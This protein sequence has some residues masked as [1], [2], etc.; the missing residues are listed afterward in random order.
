MATK[1]GV[2]RSEESRAKRKRVKA[3]KRSGRPI[4]LTKLS[5]VREG[6]A[7]AKKMHVEWDCPEGHGTQ[8]RYRNQCYTCGTRRT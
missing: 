2:H 5:H 3:P 7:P 6:M 8:P 1:P 4:E